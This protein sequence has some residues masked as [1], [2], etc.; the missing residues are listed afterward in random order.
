MN[1]KYCYFQLITSYN[2]NSKSFIKTNGSLKSFSSSINMFDNFIAYNKLLF[3]NKGNVWKLLNLDTG[4]FQ[5]L[6]LNIDAYPKYYIISENK[7][8]IKDKTGRY[9]IVEVALIK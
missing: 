8:L 6:K 5:L 9:Y 1:D 3:H 2:S 4:K 7:I